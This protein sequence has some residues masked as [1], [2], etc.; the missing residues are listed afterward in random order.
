[1]DIIPLNLQRKASAVNFILK[2]KEQKNF[3]EKEI[4]LNVA[5][6]YVKRGL[7]I[8]SLQPIST[9]A[10]DILNLLPTKGEEIAMVHTF[11]STIP[12]WELHRATFDIDNPTFTKSTQPTLLKQLTLEHLTKCYPNH[13]KIYT[14]GSKSDK[15]DTGAAFVIPSLNIVKY[16]HIGKCYS[17][18]TAELI[19]ILQALKFLKEMITTPDKVLFCVDSK[20]VLTSLKSSFN[21]NREN[22]ILEI[23]NIVSDLIEKGSNITFF[24]IP[25]HIGL[26]G[27][28]SADKAAKRGAQHSATATKINIPLAFHEYKCEIKGLVKAEFLKSLENSNDFYSAH[29][30]SYTLHI[31]PRVLWKPAI[32]ARS[33]E[34]SSTIFKLRLNALNTKYINNVSCICKKTLSIGHIIKE[35]P[36]LRDHM[37]DLQGYEKPLDWILNNESALFQLATKLLSSDIKTS[38]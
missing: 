32:Q 26:Y 4:R 35:C 14:D 8:N 33:R 6:D 34:I 12:K 13:T 18:Y 22:L 7:T 3:C 17:I 37:K 28:E 20:A 16:F 9:Y 30:I 15:G 27:N 24:W 23:Q 5:T 29:C 25:A 21:K 11:Q 38:L 10:S 2:S 36:V 19:G 1:M 31:N